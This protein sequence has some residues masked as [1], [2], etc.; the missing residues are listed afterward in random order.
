MLDALRLSEGCFKPRLPAVDLAVDLAELA[1]EEGYGGDDERP[2]AR[3]D[4]QHTFEMG[5]AT[6]LNGHAAI[7]KHAGGT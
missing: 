6:Q 3:C 1:V 5:A 4:L 7:Q 2:Q